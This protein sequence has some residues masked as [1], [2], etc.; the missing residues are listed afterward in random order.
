MHVEIS[1]AVIG[2]LISIKAD[3]ESHM[4]AIAIKLHHPPSVLLCTSLINRDTDDLNHLYL[5][6]WSCNDGILAAQQRVVEL[7][8]AVAEATLYYDSSA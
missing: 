1:Q 5:Q 8:S 6:R 7:Q 3:L 2:L 4:H